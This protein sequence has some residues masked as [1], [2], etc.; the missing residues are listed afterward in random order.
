[1]S[2]QEVILQQLN[3]R[4]AVK[5][6]DPGK[7]ISESDWKVLEESLRLAPSSYG[8]QPWKFWIVQN[9]AMRLQ[10]REASWKQSQ[11][12]D[13]SHF[14]V[15]LHKPKMDVEFIDSFIQKIAQ[16]R[17][18]SLESL[19][20]FKN[21]MVRDLIN[22]PR[23]EVIHHWAE[24][25]TYIAM[26]MLMETAAL[27]EIDTCPMEGLDPKQYDKILGLDGTHWAT[28]AAV[29]CGY[30]AADDS[31]QFNKKVRFDRDQIF[32]II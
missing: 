10:L 24:R 19:Q 13:C 27:L 2:P 18:V 26:G 28:V 4:Y 11:V 14:V 16:V 22:G 25:Q 1:M 31:F 21:G 6:F 5:K 20:G 12:T 23:A 9:P 17:G 8:L 7:K 29:A 30:R 32:K 3:W 15:L